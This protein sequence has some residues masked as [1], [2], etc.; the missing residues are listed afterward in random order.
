MS[1]LETTELF[2]EKVA[3]KT[4]KTINKKITTSKKKRTQKYFFLIHLNFYNLNS[5][6]LNLDQALSC[7]K[8]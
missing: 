6:A 1:P 4:P 2:S 7:K 3:K 5:F 8:Q